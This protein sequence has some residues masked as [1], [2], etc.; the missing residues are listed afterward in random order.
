MLRRGKVQRVKLQ[1]ERHE[2]TLAS[3][4][5]AP[6]RLPKLKKDLHLV[7][8]ALDYGDRIIISND[9]KAATGFSEL[10]RSIPEFR[11]HWWGPDNPIP[12]R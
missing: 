3:C 5:L 9:C 10:S 8:A 6:E 7:A 11:V 4:D 2:E 1:L 12:D